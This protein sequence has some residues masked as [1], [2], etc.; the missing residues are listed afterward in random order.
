MRS[1]I[2]NAIQTIDIQQLQLGNPESFR[3]LYRIMGDEL[4]EEAQ[5]TPMTKEDRELIV[6]LS[7]ISCWFRCGDLLSA[8]QVVGMLY[9]NHSVLGTTDAITRGLIFALVL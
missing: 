1:T 4:T 5:L 7:F 2:E 8:N 3:H 9:C 6:Q